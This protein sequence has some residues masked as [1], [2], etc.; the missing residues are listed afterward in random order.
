MKFMRKGKDGYFYIPTRADTRDVPD[1]YSWPS[2]EFLITKLQKWLV[3]LKVETED[4]KARLEI[5]KRTVALMKKREP[6]TGWLL[7]FV[8]IFMPHDEIFSKSYKWQRPKQVEESD[9]DEYFSNDDGFFSNL[10]QLDD[11]TIKKTNRLA[12]PKHARVKKQLK[13]LR[14]RQERDRKKADAL[15]MAIEQIDTDSDD[16]LE[17]SELSAEE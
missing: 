12:Q 9:E 15:E 7:L 16:E 3:S 1:C 10:P 11:K 8:G 5:Y 6:D 2:K 13:A 4:E 17:L 14:A